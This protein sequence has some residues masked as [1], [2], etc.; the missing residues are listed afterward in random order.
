[1]EK[2]GLPQ[3]LGVTVIR[4]AGQWVSLPEAGGRSGGGGGGMGGR[5]G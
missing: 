3:G 1:M 4:D 2:R 5:A